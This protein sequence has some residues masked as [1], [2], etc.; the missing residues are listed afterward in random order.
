MNQ[1]GSCL[2]AAFRVAARFAGPSRSLFA[3]FFVSFVSFVCFVGR[4]TCY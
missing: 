2:R 1:P 3:V 4:R